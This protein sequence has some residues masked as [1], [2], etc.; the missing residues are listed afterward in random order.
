MK[1]IDSELVELAKKYGN[2]DNARDPVVIARYMST[3][4]P[5]VWL[6]IDFDPETGE[7]VAYKAGIGDDGWDLFNLLE[8]SQL[9]IPTTTTYYDQASKRQTVRKSFGRVIRDNVFTPRRLSEVMPEVKPDSATPY[10][11]RDLAEMFGRNKDTEKAQ[12]QNA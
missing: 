12:A 8:L 7:A 3:T 5:A 9:R 2:Q 4:S 11:L 1:L 6:V 10:N